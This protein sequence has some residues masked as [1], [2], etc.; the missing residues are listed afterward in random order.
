MAYYTHDGIRHS[1]QEEAL[2]YLKQ[3][4]TTVSPFND[5]Y[6]QKIHNHDWGKYEVQSIPDESDSVYI[7]LTRNYI[8]LGKATG[9]NQI[10]YYEESKPE[11]VEE[12]LSFLNKQASILD[13]ISSEVRHYVVE[14]SKDGEHVNVSD[15]ENTIKL[16]LNLIIN[17][18]EEQGEPSNSMF[19]EYTFEDIIVGAVDIT[20][21]DPLHELLLAIENHIILEVEGE[22]SED[23]VNGYNVFHLIDTAQR[24]DM[25]ISIKLSEKERETEEED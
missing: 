3:L 15:D 2:E 13:M 5:E 4:I 10:K 14:W 17:H 8:H 1:T 22:I 16:S 12:M 24:E 18:G 11:E 19:I 23:V 7:E 21:K 20:D 9:T 25:N 6:A